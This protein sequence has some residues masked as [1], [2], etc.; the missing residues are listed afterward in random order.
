MDLAPVL[1]FAQP[2]FE[3]AVGGFEGGV[4]TVGAGFAAHHR[5]TPAGGDLDVLTV[6][7]LPPILLVVELDIEEVDGAVESFQAGQ[8]VGHVL[9]EVVRHLDV[10]P[11][12]DDV[13]VTGGFGRFAVHDHCA[14][15]V[16]GKT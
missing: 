4:E 1:A 2:G 13:G 15:G 16:H 7:A 11:R 3:F 6:L 5:A 12:H 14:V 10:A 9:T 8:L